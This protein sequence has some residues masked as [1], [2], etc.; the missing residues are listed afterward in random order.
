MFGATQMPFHCKKRNIIFKQC[1]SVSSVEKVGEPAYF[2]IT[3]G[4]PLTYLYLRLQF[5]ILDHI[6]TTTMFFHILGSGKKEV[7]GRGAG[8]LLE[9]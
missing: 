6:G 1:I 9:S 7:L 5:F 8:L 4:F 2:N 3:P